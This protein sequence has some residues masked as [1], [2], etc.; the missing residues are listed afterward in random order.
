M[1]NKLIKRIVFLRKAEWSKSEIME[2]KQIG[3][4]PTWEQPFYPIKKGQLVKFDK[5]LIIQAI[6]GKH[7]QDKLVENTTGL[8]EL[9]KDLK[10]LH[11]E[12]GGITTFGGKYLSVDSNHKMLNYSTQG[13]GGEAMK[14]YIRIVHKLFKEA[15]LI[16]GVDFLHSATI[17]DEIDMIC[18]SKHS[19]T[20]TDILQTSYALT[21]KELQMKTTFTGEV[22]TGS[23]WGQCH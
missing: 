4:W 1:E 19:K 9:I 20:I 12:K 10:K 7:I 5:K 22:L 3:D 13:N 18:K 23:N 21:S 6:F 2:Y 17:Y 15:G 14:T 16:H 8:A 11:K